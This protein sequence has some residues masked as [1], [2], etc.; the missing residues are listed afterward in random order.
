MEIKSNQI[1]NWS[2]KK[3]HSIITKLNLE[4][5]NKMMKKQILGFDNKIDSCC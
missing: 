2:N 4:H 5:N 1:C 3:G